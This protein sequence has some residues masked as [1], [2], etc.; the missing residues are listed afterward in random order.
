MKVM[1]VLI[2]PDVPVYKTHHIDEEGPRQ[3]GGPSYQLAQAEI[4]E[5]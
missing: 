2:R 3:P 4:E 5:L 1:V